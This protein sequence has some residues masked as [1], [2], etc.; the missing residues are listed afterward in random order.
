MRFKYLSYEL[1]LISTPFPP[2]ELAP[3]LCLVIE[4]LVEFPL[5]GTSV[6]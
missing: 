5:E 6:F 4:D 1:C 2:G 3:G